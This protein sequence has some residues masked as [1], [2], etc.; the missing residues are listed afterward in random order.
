METGC[1]STARA[2]AERMFPAMVLKKGSSFR[3]AGARGNLFNFARAI[4]FTRVC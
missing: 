1:E 2:P 3:S 4:S